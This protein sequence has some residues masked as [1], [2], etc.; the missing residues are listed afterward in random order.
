M[1]P[2]P[3]GGRKAVRVRLEE[4]GE[5]LAE[6]ADGFLD[7]EREPLRACGRRPF[8]E[9]TPEIGVGEF[10]QVVGLDGGALFDHAPFGCEVPGLVSVRRNL[11]LPGGKVAVSVE[12]F[13]PEQGR[14][15]KKL[16][17]LET[18]MAAFVSGIVGG[19]VENDGG[20]LLD[21]VFVE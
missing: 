3:R 19:G 1:L 14:D 2:P 13:T 10:A 15:R 16:E 11:G 9:Q 5:L 7:Q 20:E 21:L 6:R 4:H 8:V 18:T 17:A 12:S